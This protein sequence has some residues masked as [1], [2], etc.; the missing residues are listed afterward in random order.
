MSD[1]LAKMSAHDTNAEW[2]LDD[3]FVAEAV[4]DPGAD[5]TKKREA[6]DR[7]VQAWPGNGMRHDT[8][9][10]QHFKDALGLRRWAYF[11]NTKMFMGRRS[12]R[13]PCPCVG[14]NHLPTCVHWTFPDAPGFIELAATGRCPAVWAGAERA[15]REREA[16]ERSRLRAA[17]PP[18]KPQPQP[19]KRP[20]VPTPVGPK[21]TPSSR[22]APPPVRARALDFEE[23]PKDAELARSMA[24]NTR[25]TAENARQKSEIQRLKQEIAAADWQRDTHKGLA[26]QRRLERDAAVATAAAAVQLRDVAEATVTAA[27]KGWERV[28]DVDNIER[29]NE[30]LRKSNRRLSKE[31]SYLRT[32]S[33]LEPMAFTDADR[34]L[35][36]RKRTGKT[37]LVPKKSWSRRIHRVSATLKLCYTQAFIPT[38]IASL[39]VSRKDRRDAVL[40]KTRM[41]KYLTRQVEKSLVVAAQDPKVAE[42]IFLAAKNEKIGYVKTERFMKRITRK[43][44]AQTQKN[45]ALVFATLGGLVRHFRPRT[46]KKMLSAAKKRLFQKFGPGRHP[47]FPRYTLLK[48][49]EGV[50]VGVAY[51]FYDVVVTALALAFL[52]HVRKHLHLIL[53]DSLPAGHYALVVGDSCDKFP[54]DK[55]SDATEWTL[56]VRVLLGVA[57]SPNRQHHVLLGNVSDR[58][59]GPLRQICLERD[60]D[61]ARLAAESAGSGIPVPIYDDAPSDG[62]APTTFRYV[63]LR[64][65]LDVHSD[66]DD[67]GTVTTAQNDGMQWSEFEQMPGCH[68]ADVGGSVYSVTK[69]NRAD[70]TFFEEDLALTKTERRYCL[71]DPADVARHIEEQG[72]L[73]LA[74]LPGPASE[75]RA[76]LE[77]EG[78]SGADLDAATVDALVVYVR[79]SGTSLARAYKEKLRALCLKNSLPQSTGRRAYIFCRVHGW[80]ILHLAT[81]EAAAATA[82][83]FKLVKT[84]PT[85]CDAFL[86]AMRAEHKQTR[87]VATRLQNK[88]LPKSARKKKPTS[89]RYNGTGADAWNMGGP[90]FAAALEGIA[91]ESYYLTVSAIFARVHLARVLVSFQ[92]KYTV[93]LVDIEP[94]IEV[95]R[96]MLRLSAR[97]HLGITYGLHYLCY[98]NLQYL[99]LVSKGLKVNSEECLGLQALAS[100]KGAEGKHADTK[101]RK[102]SDTNSH[103]DWAFQLSALRYVSAIAE[104]DDDFRVGKLDFHAKG[105]ERFADER[106]DGFCACGEPLLDDPDGHRDDEEEDAGAFVEFLEAHVRLGGRLCDH[107][108]GVKAFLVDASQKNPATW[109]ASATYATMVQ[110]TDE[111]ATGAARGNYDANGEEARLAEAQAEDDALLREALPSDSDDDDEEDEDDEEEEPAVDVGDEDDEWED[112]PSDEDEDMLTGLGLDSD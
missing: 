24:E 4:G 98:G 16:A 54:A 30:Q 15:A 21:G 61:E 63:H 90:R 104:I 9:M 20:A 81:N 45:E 43:W 69:V 106:K 89:F 41:I 25:L 49:D 37:E 100:A 38:A 112:I 29:K 17:S 19:K 53:D 23:D 73:L 66:L 22:G 59:T 68:G 10:R 34:T 42:R 60:A 97:L 92:S 91:G 52:P 57:N 84:R 96:M 5:A 51:R 111:A 50:T 44:N 12:S 48:N 36:T 88:L 101:L 102:V 46:S 35:V 82:Q 14:P 7:L 1:T 8:M 11:N 27:L 47:L 109:E 31:N 32:G 75:A 2:L 99:K 3:V 71:Y 105:L 67:V 93:K 95:G 28:E 65:G 62:S 72:V 18:P 79:E 108:R 74:E 56:S 78:R 33:K 103:A 110:E 64:N 39:V 85:A 40:Q 83:T 58:D 70:A 13:A 26:E 80:C 94:M 55:Q 107:C 77:A 6:R 87:K 86:N 76:R